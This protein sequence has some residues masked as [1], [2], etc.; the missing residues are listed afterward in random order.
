MSKLET[1]GT[2][3]V[4][5]AHEHALSKRRKVHERCWMPVFTNLST[6]CF[7]KSA[8]KSVMNDTAAFQNR[9]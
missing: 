7:V 3:W 9:L 1:T 8:L 2:E 6:T 5:A 4:I